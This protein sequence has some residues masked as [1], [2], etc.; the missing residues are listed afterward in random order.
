MNHG[1]VQARGLFHSHCQ[2]T[3]YTEVHESVDIRLIRGSGVTK[4]EYLDGSSK[5]L[6]AIGNRI[7][8]DAMPEL[9]VSASVQNPNGTR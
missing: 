3:V 5:S 6:M 2:K 8:N 7:H 4:A 1:I 9:E